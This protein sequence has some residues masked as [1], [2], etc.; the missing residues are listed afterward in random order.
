MAAINT[1]DEMSDN[2]KKSLKESLFVNHGASKI[3]KWPNFWFQ[4]AIKQ[5]HSK[6]P[7]I[8]GLGW[9]IYRQQKTVKSHQFPAPKSHETTKIQ[10]SMS[11]RHW[12]LQPVEEEGFEWS[13]IQIPYP[14]QVP[15]A[16]VQYTGWRTR[17]LF[18]MATEDSINSKTKRWRTRWK[19]F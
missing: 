5:L 15:A 18:K 13:P 4:N 19:S 8:W 12:S 6:F 2:S 3:C 7:Y 14:Q 9:R 11:P 16:P 17:T 1:K 10:I